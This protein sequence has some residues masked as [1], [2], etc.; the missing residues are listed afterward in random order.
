MD[1]YLYDEHTQ[2][3]RKSS[4][5]LWNILTGI[6]LLMM[7]C[8]S[9]V[10]L[11]IFFNPQSSFNPFPPAPLPAALKFPTITPTS[12]VKLRPTWTPTPTEEPTATVTPHPTATLPPTPTF[13][14]L[15]SPT[16]EPPTAT[17]GGM[18][19]AINRGSPSALSSETFHPEAGCDWMGV[20]G[21]VLDITNAPVST[22]VIIQLGGSLAG[23]P[24]DMPTLPGLA[25][26][27]GPSGYEIYL[28]DHP[29]ASKGSL[30]LQ[31]LDQAGLPLSDK[32]YFDTR[33][34]CEHNLTFITIKQMRR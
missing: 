4:A 7:L 11:T 8:A 21:T 28:S 29:I 6:V 26:Q 31:L 22:G 33:D 16:P 3:Q 2:T 23:A 5:L 18:P 24:L 27:Y 17:S 10:F 1:A 15:V 34:D 20:A 19:F 12:L 9:G 14:S 25:R 32:I 30:Y 13:F